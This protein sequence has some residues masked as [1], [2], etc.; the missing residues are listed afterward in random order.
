MPDSGGCFGGKGGL[1]RAGYR[2]EVN[3]RRAAGR[4]Q[5]RAVAALAYGVA[6]RSPCYG[7]DYTTFYEDILLNNFKVFAGESF[8]QI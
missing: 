1:R 5:F 6:S 3:K 4:R 8:M 2:C 7:A